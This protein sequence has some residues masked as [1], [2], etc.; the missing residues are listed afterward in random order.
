MKKLKLNKIMAG[1]ISVC[2]CVADVSATCISVSAGNVIKAN[3]TPYEWYLEP[4]IQADDIIVY[5]IENDSSGDNFKH[6]VIRE[7]AYIQQNGLWG[8]IGYDGNFIVDAKYSNKSGYTCGLGLSV[9][10]GS[11]DFAVVHSGD[12]GLIVN[13]S[14]GGIGLESELFYI[15]KSTGELW[16]T[17][18]GTGKFSEY[19]E[20]SSFKKDYY[21]T[22]KCFVVREITT[23]EYYDNGNI[24]INNEGENCNVGK[25]GIANKNGIVIPCEYDNGR[26]YRDNIYLT[27]IFSECCAMQKGDKWA[28]FNNS[29]IQITDFI[30]DSYYDTKQGNP[31]I[32]T[33]YLPTENYIAVRNENGAGYC[34]IEGKE[35]IPTGTFEEVRPVHNGLAWVKYDG[36]WGVLDIEKTVDNFASATTTTTATTQ[37][38]T[39]PE[40][41][42]TTTTTT[43]NI[44]TPPYTEL[45]FGDINNDRLIDAVD[46]AAVLIEYAN[47]STGKDSTLSDEQKKVADING[48]G[49]I[50]AVDATFILRYY[51]KISTGG[52]M[53]L[54]EFV[55]NNE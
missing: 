9:G 53:T 13:N 36:L 27:D 1:L 31:S 49:L 5:D 23:S 38:T 47:L 48:D 33:V 34:T 24:I 16:F 52:N 46:A 17:G 29:G 12:N 25:Y 50:D 4:S 8:I 30:Y 20:K 21:K 43:T 39:T 41:N 51:A 45:E 54:A 42:D 22:D 37:T 2:L 6:Q 32:K 40:L 10:N 19:Y 44:V 35:I 3:Q 28:Y 26:Y 11:N 18:F 15:E 55:E 7:C 14:Y